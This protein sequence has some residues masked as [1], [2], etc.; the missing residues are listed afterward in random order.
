MGN[1]TSSTS[2]T[3]QSVLECYGADGRFDWDLYW[4]YRRN[5]LDDDD[6]D[7]FQDHTDAVSECVRLADREMEELS[8]QQ[9][10][11]RRSC[12]SNPMMMRSSDGTLVPMLPTNS[13]WYSLYVLNPDVDD[14]K[15]QRKFRLRFR[16]PHNKYLELLEKIRGHYM[17]DRWNREDATGKPASPLSLMLLGALRYL[18]RGWSFDDLEEATAISEECHRQ[19]FHVFIGYGSTFLYD[20]WVKYPRNAE[21]AAE[22]MHEHTLAGFDGCVGSMD[23]THIGMERCS[24][25]M[26]NHMTGGKLSMP[27][28]TYNITVNHR[29][30]ILYTTSGHPARWNDKTLQLYDEFACGLYY[31]DILEDNEFTLI[32]RDPNGP[33]GTE[34]RRRTY[35]GAWLLADN[36]YINWPTVIP[37]SKT[38]TRVS[39]DRFSKWLESMRKDVECTFGIM[40]GRFRV[41]KV[42]CRLHGVEACDKIWLTCCSLHNYLLDADGLTGQWT[43]GEESDWTGRLGLHEEADRRNV[44]FAV[45]RL[46]NAGNI[47]GYNDEYIQDV[48][49]DYDCSGMGGRHGRRRRRY[50]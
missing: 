37:P 22:H 28:R 34:T 45:W 48:P 25:G 12:K 6:D 13:S 40:K 21:E 17:F 3:P 44:S 15:W 19:F 8:N 9:P 18:G 24:Y 23:A 27:S 26:S 31:G 49:M 30:Q 38:V 43:E 50:Y 33:T 42:G 47:A 32:E 10:P 14:E 11:R 39:E 16:L 36:G 7:D 1:T 5:E 2:F 46:N 4:L 29:R 35:K 41:L 20:E